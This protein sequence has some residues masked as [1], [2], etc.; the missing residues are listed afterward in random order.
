MSYLNLYFSQNNTYFLF[1]RE[2]LWGWGKK[3]L[4]DGIPRN[5]ARPYSITT[6][7]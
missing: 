2:S 4:A 5:S 6:I 1:F 7:L 3:I